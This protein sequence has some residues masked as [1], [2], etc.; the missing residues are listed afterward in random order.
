MTYPTTVTSKGTITLPAEIRKALAIRPGQRVYVGMDANNQVSISLPLDIK[1]IRRANQEHL[2]KIG[3]TY[4]SLTR[5]EINTGIA[6]Q[7]VER[8]LRSHNVDA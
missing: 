6:Q 7:A 8:H 2:S 4:R 5:D 3:V 1:D